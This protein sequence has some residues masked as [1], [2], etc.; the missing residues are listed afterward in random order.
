MDE[1][2][3][4]DTRSAADRR[5]RWMRSGGLIGAGFVAGGV[6]AAAF[7]ASAATDTAGTATPAAATSSS[8]SSS[9]SGDDGTRWSGWWRGHGDGRSSDVTAAEADKVKAAVT[10]RYPGATVGWV[11]KTDDGAFHAGLHTTDGKHVEVTLDGSFAITSAKE[12]T[13]DH[14]GRWSGSQ[15]S[16]QATDAVKAAVTKRYPGASVRWVWE[17]GDGKYHAAVRTSDGKRLEVTLDT[18]YAITATR[19]LP[20]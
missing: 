13:D 11:W 4:P 16:S 19:T 12:D 6:L 2:G 17:E 9:S 14:D 1:H 18:S 5:R 10:K 15:V 20:D 8:S 7:S 3:T